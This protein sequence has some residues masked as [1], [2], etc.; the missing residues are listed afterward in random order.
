MMIL[1]IR[2]PFAWAII[3][4]G[5]DIE[6][7]TWSTKFRDRFFVHAS[8]KFDMEGWR[9][10]AVNPNRL[11]IQQSIHELPYLTSFL[12]GG[13]IGSVELV[14]CVQSHGSLWFSGPY[15]FLLKNPE[16]LVFQECKSKLGFF[17]RGNKE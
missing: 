9:W 14:D 16:P 17:N 7:R 3:H 8:R 2:Q 15:G 11:W 1:S 10:I 13:I 6:S 4:G 12:R 5:K